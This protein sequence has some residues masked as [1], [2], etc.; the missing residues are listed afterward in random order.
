MK[1]PS[2][3]SKESVSKLLCQARQQIEQQ[4]RL[5]P[6][7]H[8]SDHTGKTISVEL[9]LPGQ[10][11]K[12]TDYLFSKGQSLNSLGWFPEEAAVVFQSGFFYGYTPLTS[13]PAFA[14]NFNCEEAVVV[15]RRS[16]DGICFTE[17]VQSFRRDKQDHPIWQPII[18][19]HY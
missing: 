10:V 18:L 1:T 2:I 12:I 7:L 16:G 11:E 15:T 17:V 4:M 13:Q 8:M 9:I 19:A 3:L 14:G 5:V 6:T